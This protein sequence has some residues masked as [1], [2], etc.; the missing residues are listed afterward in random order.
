MNRKRIRELGI[1]IGTLQPGEFNAITDVAGVQ[2]GQATLI[3]DEPRVARTG[4]TLILPRAGKVWNDHC[5][6]AYHSFNGCGELTGMHW[7]TESGMLTCP[8]ALTTT[9]HV[10]T[11]HES[12]VSYG[13]REGLGGAF[14]LAV[15]GE[16]WDGYLNDM[17]AGHIKDEHVLEALADAHSGPVPEGNVGGGTGMICHGFKGGTGTSSR[18]VPIGDENYTVGAL[19]QANYG[20]RA[21]FRLDGVPVG[22]LIGPDKVPPPGV[23]ETSSSS[24]IV[25]LATDAP[26]L[27]GQCRRL[28]QRA[29][30][31]LARV[32]GFGHNGSGDIFLAFSTGN[33]LAADAEEP[34]P[35]RVL[36]NHKMNPLFQAVA[37][38]VEESILNALTAAETTTGYKG[39]TAHALPLEGLKE[40][41]DQYRPVNPED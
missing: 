2:I 17:G 3:Y 16:T 32:G 24:I 15:V 5:F 6:A 38:A 41:V 31:G 10:G 12:I 13:Q 34:Y 22:R 21:D 18:M 39:R 8:V 4:V 11:V 37:E 26:L 35:V 29:T 1:T 23:A 28:A 7:V 30:V 9:H 36:P 25:V 14:S 40:L 27:P 19:V 33:H 20:A